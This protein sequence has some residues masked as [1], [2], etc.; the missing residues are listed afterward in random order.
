MLLALRSFPKNY[1]AFSRF[2]ETRP[3]LLLSLPNL[4]NLQVGSFFTVLFNFQ[5]PVLLSEKPG[6]SDK[7]YLL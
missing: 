4:R 5:A 3:V 7:A 2:L 6:L 1:L